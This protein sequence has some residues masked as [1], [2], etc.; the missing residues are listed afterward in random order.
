MSDESGQQLAWEDGLIGR[1]ALPMYHT[2]PLEAGGATAVAQ[3]ATHA[4]RSGF[5]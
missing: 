2:Q 3:S 5:G 1:Y 4:V